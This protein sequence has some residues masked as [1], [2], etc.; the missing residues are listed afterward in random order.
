MPAPTVSL[1]PLI[2]RGKSEP[3]GTYRSWFLWDDR[4][5]IFGSIRRGLTAVVREIDAGTFGNARLEVRRRPGE[6][7]QGRGFVLDSRKS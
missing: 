2:E 7:W 3:G 4:L 6:D 1:T 5:K